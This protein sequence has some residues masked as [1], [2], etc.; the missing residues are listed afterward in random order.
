MDDKKEQALR[1][2]SDPQPG[3]ISV[4]AT[5]SFSS[6]EDLALAYTPGVAE[7]CLEIAKSPDNVYKYTAKG[8][9][10]A[11][12]SNGTAVLGLGNIGP[13]AGKPVM[14]GKAVLFKKFAGI[15]VFDIEIAENDPEKL[16][17]TIARLEPTFG[18]INLEDIKAPECFYVEEELKKRMKIPVFHDDQHGTAIIIAAGLLNA[19][20]LSGRKTADVRVVF[21]GAGSAAIAS[22]NLLISLGIKRENIYM[23]DSEGLITEERLSKLNKYKVSFAQKQNQTLAECLIGADVFIGVSVA[24]ILSAEMVQSMAKQPIVFALANPNPEIKYED[25]IKAVPDIIMASG[26]SD[27]PNQI[28]NVLAFPYIFRGALDV[29]ASEINEAMK[30]AAV[31]AIAE[32]AKEEVPPEIEQI[33]GEKFSFGARYIIPKPFD[34]RLLPRVASAVAL[35]AETSGVARIKI[36]LKEYFKKLNS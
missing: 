15:D 6:K 32:L 24:N 16:V 19:L 26:R 9:L 2:H 17:E 31:K 30:V 14:E 8:N 23:F 11:V 4:V 20:E 21:S 35:V 3:K 33:Y 25:A 36:D 12:I 5:K 22:A 1:Y 29:R 13:L 7:P 10:V 28:N 27:Y 18:G 34:T